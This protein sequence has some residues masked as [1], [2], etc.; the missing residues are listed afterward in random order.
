MQPFPAWA[1]HAVLLVNLACTWFMVGLIW[2]VQVVHYPLFTRVGEAAWE[3]YHDTH[4]RVITFVVAPM[5]L[6]EAMGAVALLAFAKQFS[7]RVQVCLLMAAGLALVNWLSTIGVQ[8]PLHN[9]LAAQFDPETIRRL[10]LT[11]WVRTAAW[12]ARGLLLAYVAWQIWGAPLSASR[13]GLP[14]PPPG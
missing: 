9:R 4:G 5:M 11:N 2:I 13:S 12:T 10:V 8:V 6:L 1:P 14:E 3:A 7:G